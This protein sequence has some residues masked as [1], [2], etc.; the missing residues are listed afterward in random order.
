MNDPDKSR[1]A[2]DRLD[3]G[4][5]TADPSMI[6]FMAHTIG[7]GAPEI[8]RVNRRTTQ[9]R[10]DVRGSIVK[11]NVVDQIEGAARCGYRRVEIA[12][13]QATTA[14][15][16]RGPDGV[17]VAIVPFGQG[18]V[19]HM[20]VH[21]A[22]PDLATAQRFFGD[23]LGWQVDGS[24]VRFGA[25]LVMLE[26]DAAAPT[27]NP[28]PASTRGWSYLTVQI[29]DCDAETASAVKAGALVARAPRTYG[30][31]A[32]FSMITDPWGNH[33]ELSQRASLTGPLPPNEPEGTNT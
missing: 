8:L 14:T 6:D 3:V 12:N 10:F 21:M 30:E 5:M 29:R 11:I 9:H 24:R 15:E 27:G 1:F 18:G 16:F 31:V 7:L 13:E 22:V 28:D 23:G 26:Q 19:D 2:K 4:L 20:A 32:R 33:V 25:S 17:V